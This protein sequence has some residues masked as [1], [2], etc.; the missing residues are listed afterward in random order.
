MSVHKHTATLLIITSDAS[1]AERLI[2]ALREDGIATQS[3]TVPHAERLAEVIAQRGC[4]LILC[5]SYQREVDLDSVLASHRKL[6]G[7]IPLILIEESEQHAANLAKIRRSAVR[8]LIRRHDH[9]HLKL[10]VAREFAELLRRREA[11]GLNQRLRL[12]EQRDRELIAVTSA[13][14]SFVQDGLHLDANPAYLALFGYPDLDELQAIPFLDLFV[15]EYQKKI[16][17]LLRGGDATALNEPVELTV[18]CR[19]HDASQFNARLLAAPAEIDHEPC[20][21]LLVHPLDAPALVTPIAISAEPEIS[22]AAPAPVAVNAE[23]AAPGLAQLL[24]EITGHL[25]AEHRIERPFAIFYLQLK[26][27]TQLLRDLGL[28]LGLEQRDAYAAQLSTLVAAEHGFCAR[29]TDDGFVVLVDDVNE[30]EAKALA[31][32]LLTTARLPHR[33]GTQPDDATADFDMGYYL[34]RD[35]AGAAEDIVNAAYRLCVGRESVPTAPAATP[36]GDSEAEI[37]RRV[38]RALAQD[39]FKLVYQPIISLMGDDQENYSVLVRL[40]DEHEPPL[41]ARDFVG[42]ATRAGLIEQVDRWTI[43]S[44]IQVIGEQRR[45]GQRISLF[46]SLAE[47]T[48]RNPSIVLWICDCLREFDVRGNWL[49]FQFQEEVVTNNLASLNKLMETLKKIK[50]RVALHRFGLLAHP[51]RLLQN[52]PLDYVLLKSTFAQ[53]LANDPAK[54]QRLVALAT[55]AHEFNVKTIVTGVEDAQSLTVLWTAGVDYVQ[56]NFLQR[57]SP[58]L[59]IT[60]GGR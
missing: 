57:P 11:A 22:A 10:A 23:I 50:C 14:V 24:A 3:V 5:C 1:D 27:G 56:G 17:E 34:V 43:R 31:E 6:I 41:E 7:D 53:G 47:D 39:H 42:P 37:A 33:A 59:D 52:L 9:D 35:R 58:T 60:S 38:E 21:R 13:G 49:T 15:P 28:T 4:D 16:R 19:R 44:A 2:G 54:Q 26:D 48:F 55:M 12:C 51:E 18:I 45:A 30:L 8:D 25:N 40:I 29:V 36:A 32:R 20:L 46:I